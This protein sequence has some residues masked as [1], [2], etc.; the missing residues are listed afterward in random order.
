MQLERQTENPALDV[1]SSL[2]FT[3]CTRFSSTSH[4]QPPEIQI[5]RLLV[6]FPFRTHRYFKVTSAGLK[7]FSKEKH[8]MKCVC[9]QSLG[10]RQL[11]LLY[12][13][14]LNQ[15]HSGS[16]A[17]RLHLH[18][19]R[20][21]SWRPIARDHAPGSTRARFRGAVVERRLR[22]QRYNRERDISRERVCVRGI[23]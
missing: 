15:P 8:S 16:A 11:Y 1:V 14:F 23:P 21:I 7:A 5:L 9:V 19:S 3:C 2:Y 6:L 17:P 10:A 18:A 22:K 20:S 13:R 4:Y 12:S